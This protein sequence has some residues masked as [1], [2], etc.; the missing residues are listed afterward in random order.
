VYAATLIVLPRRGSHRKRRARWGKDQDQ[1]QTDRPMDQ[2][3]GEQG[4]DDRE[5]H[6]DLE[7]C[8]GGSS[9]DVVTSHAAGVHTNVT[10]RRVGD[11]EEMP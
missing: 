1:S 7:C 3:N 8:Q 2:P 5:V 9:L 4:E 6:G 10:Q 11:S